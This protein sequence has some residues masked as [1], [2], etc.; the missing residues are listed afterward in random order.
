MFVIALINEPENQALASYLSKRAKINP[1]GQLIRDSSVI[2]G[3]LALISSALVFPSALNDELTYIVQADI[4][5]LRFLQGVIAEIDMTIAL[6]FFLIGRYQTYSDL[7]DFQSGKPSA[8]IIARADRSNKG[9]LERIFDWGMHNTHNNVAIL[10][11]V[12]CLLMI[13]SGITSERWGEAITGFF[14]ITSYGA[15]LLPEQLD[16]LS[17]DIN[18]DRLHK[19][20]WHKVKSNPLM[21]SSVIQLLRFMPV[22]IHAGLES[23]YYQVSQYILALIMLAF[24]SDTTKHGVGRYAGSIIDQNN[25]HSLELTR[26]LLEGRI[27]RKPYLSSAE[28]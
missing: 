5:W 6:I 7:A 4:N 9:A 28:K 1:L 13:A 25:K 26:R 12:L 8:E 16:P 19:K 11:I 27:F 20:I 22:M 15:R 17:L 18:A 2:Y 10:S 14:L 23:D 3:L 24:L 21:A